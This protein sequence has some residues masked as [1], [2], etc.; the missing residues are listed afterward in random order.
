MAREAAS[1]VLLRDDFSSIVQ[2]IRRGRSTFVNLRQAMVYTLAVHVP[3]V[4]L[5]VLPVVLGLPLVLAPLHIAFLELIIDPACSLVF[6]AQDGDPSLM[7]QPP[8]RVGASLLGSVHVVQG[9]VLGGMVTTVVVASYAWLLRQPGWSTAMAGTAAFIVLVTA[10]A[11]LILPSRSAQTSWRSLYSGLKP[12]TRAVL[13]CTVLALLAITAVPSLARAFGFAALAPLHW[14]AAM[15]T[16]VAM[17]G[18]FQ[19]GK[20][21]LA[22]RLPRR[23]GFRE[24]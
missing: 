23:A 8:R 15:L 16:G 19:L 18:L 14:A 11:A 21:A 9:L 24:G 20:I 17:L 1:L 2:A 6:E 22:S 7:E 10:N 5:A 12:V 13:A 3:I 4:G